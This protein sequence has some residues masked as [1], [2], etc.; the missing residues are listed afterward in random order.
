MTECEICQ[1]LREEIRELN[2][3]LTN[4]KHSEGFYDG[5]AAALTAQVEQQVKQIN[6]L[7]NIIKG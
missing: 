7:M 6:E 4:A 2:L 3:Q 1:G 5:R